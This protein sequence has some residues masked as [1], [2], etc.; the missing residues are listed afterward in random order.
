MHSARDSNHA[1]AGSRTAPTLLAPTLV[2]LSLVAGCLLGAGCSS[3][4]TRLA[5]LPFLQR[6]A[7]PETATTAEICAAVNRNQL[8]DAGQAPLSGWSSDHVRVTFSGLPAALPATLAVRSPRDLRLRIRHPL[9]G[10]DKADLGSNAERFWFWSEESGPHLMTACHAD[11]H[12]VAQ[13]LQIPFE[14][15]FVIG[16]LGL[17][18][19]QAA[20]LERRPGA[21]RDV[22]ELAEP[23]RL[24]DGHRGERVVRVSLR[25]GVVVGHELR[26]NGRMIARADIARWDTHRDTGF[27]TPAQVRL[28][29]PQSDIAMT[30]RISQTAV[31]PRTL[32]TVHFE[33]PR[34]QGVEVCDLSRGLPRDLSMAGS[35]PAP[36]SGFEHGRGLDA[37]TTPGAGPGAIQPVSSRTV[38]SH[39]VSSHEGAAAS[40]ATS[41]RDPLADFQ[42]FGESSREVAAPEWAPPPAASS[43]RGPVASSPIET[44][45]LV[46]G[47]RVDLGSPDRSA[48]ESPPPFGSPPPFERDTPTAEPP[49]RFVPPAAGPIPSSPNSAELGT[50]HP[51]SSL[52]GSSTQ[53]PSS[54][55]PA[56]STRQGTGLDPWQEASEDDPPAVIT[57]DAF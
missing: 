32:S 52:P 24:P 15:D 1:G 57:I 46:R 37:T 42:P 56:S 9:S 10:S 23:I 35:P 13:Q 27:K 20:Q 34:R 41:A 16:V 49:A 12:L 7:I 11:A 18:P 43:P 19:L 47:T 45:E 48:H 40:A 2:V 36:D 50:Q 30:L 53:P 29:W 5:R 33:M 17:Q 21:S 28:S 51:R 6:Q 55:R 22:V 38:S 25:E 39:T 26:Q 44:F 3:T 14:P 31:N 54:T 8:G 4:N